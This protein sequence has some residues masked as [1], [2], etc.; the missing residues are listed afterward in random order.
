MLIAVHKCTSSLTCASLSM[1]VTPSLSAHDASAHI[2][3]L[4]TIQ[5]TWFIVIHKSTSSLLEPFYTSAQRQPLILLSDEFLPIVVSSSNLL[6]NRL[7]W[8]HVVNLHLNDKQSKPWL[9]TKQLKLGYTPRNSSTSSF[10]SMFHHVFVSYPCCA[11]G[12]GEGVLSLYY[13]YLV[14]YHY[15]FIVWCYN[16]KMYGLLES[17]FN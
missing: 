4:D 7:T 14:S 3:L 9:N 13:M 2:K 17:L 16:T 1:P 6:S 15:G 5:C 12:E 11:W 8:D 10:L